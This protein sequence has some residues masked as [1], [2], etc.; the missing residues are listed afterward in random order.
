MAIPTYG[1]VAIF[2]TAV[3]MG[4]A[5]NPRP[6]QE[7]HFFGLNGIESLDG[8]LSGRFTE[9]RGLLGGVTVDDLAT[10]EELF[11]SYNDGRARTLVDTRGQAWA[12]VKLET[13]QPASDR[14]MADDFGLYREYTARF[15]HLV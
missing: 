2:G 7:N 8:G 10:A 11:R 9:V 14:I 4:T 3:R 12:W 13:F 15:K 5:D 1:A 6:S